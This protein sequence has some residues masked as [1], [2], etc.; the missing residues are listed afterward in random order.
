M[1]A[2]MIDLNT[3]EDAD[4]CD[5][6]SLR[7]YGRDVTTGHWQWQWLPVEVL[8]EAGRS[9]LVPWLSDAA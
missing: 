4:E 3:I 8:I 2:D 9:D 5:G 1:E 6:E 7:V